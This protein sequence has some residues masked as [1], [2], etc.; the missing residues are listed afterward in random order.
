MEF[1]RLSTEGGI[2][3][4]RLARGKV[5][6]LDPRLVDELTTCVQQLADDPEVRAI[7][8][9]GTGKFFSFGFDIPLFLGY[10]KE[11]FTDYVT[12]FTTLYRKL[13]ACPKPVV[14]AINGHAVAGGCM[15]ASA[16]DARVMVQG[17]A[18]IGLN[19]IGFGSSVFAGSVQMLMYWV[20][21]RRTQEMV[22]S[23]GL[24]AAD[25]ASSFGLID[26][27]AT[28]E[29]LMERAR[30]QALRRAAMDPVAFAS[31]KRLLRQPVIDE[32]TP[33]EAPSVREFV[34]IWYSEKTWKNLQKIEIR[35]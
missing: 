18:K 15:L 10:S 35:G 23:G 19:E 11:A 33:R 5:N 14:A 30:E 7:V 22:H 2:A 8:L 21:A 25:E 31:I 27:V 13:F 28:E 34:D 29:S 3:E 17:K 9:T 24:Y 32:F 6:A 20:G 1:V 12:R 16:C 4:V 26:T